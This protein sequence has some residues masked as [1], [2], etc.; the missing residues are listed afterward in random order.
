[1]GGI[2]RIVNGVNQFVTGQIL[3]FGTYLMAFLSATYP[4]LEELAADFWLFGELCC[5]AAA[6]PAFQGSGMVLRAMR[7]LA[8]QME[9]AVILKRV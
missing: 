7:G 9:F 8:S 4:F 1:M 6:V 3:S 2:A 5:W